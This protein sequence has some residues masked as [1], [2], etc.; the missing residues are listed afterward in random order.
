MAEHKKAPARAKA[1]SAA[2]KPRTAKAASAKNADVK[3]VTIKNAEANAP[4]R[5]AETAKP[6]SKAAEAS[7]V[8]LETVEAIKSVAVRAADAAPEARPT[9]E[10]LNAVAAPGRAVA[11]ARLFEAGTEQARAVY[12]RAQA[13]TTQLRDAVTETAT[14][15]TRGALEVNDKVLDAL[16]AQS[17]AAFDLWR[18]TLTAGSFAEAVRVQATGA[19]AVYETA[20]THWRDVAETTTRWIGAS[21]KPI[22]SAWT[23]PRR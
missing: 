1:A 16:R 21:M 8:L 6:V 22:Q 20:A 15:T 5:A 2:K 23:S 10:T 14:A 17:D 13:T 3:S 4:E 7:A 9:V 19:R 12:S 18:S 11:P